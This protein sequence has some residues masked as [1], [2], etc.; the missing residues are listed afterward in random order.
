[1]WT[2]NS[3]AL[4]YRPQKLI[5][6]LT[7]GEKPNIL[8]CGHVHKALY[9]FERHVHCVSAACTQKQTKWMR[10]K[11]LAAHTGFQLA[12]CEINKNGVAWFMSRFYPAYI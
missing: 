11:K 9:L 2:H 12:E 5:E 6:S 1:M 4:S 7:G 10:G 8:I 3:Y